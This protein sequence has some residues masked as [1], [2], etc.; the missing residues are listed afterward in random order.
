MQGS[1]RPSTALLIGSGLLTAA[2][3]AAT[4]TLIS[5]PLL[6]RIIRAAVLAVTLYTPVFKPVPLVKNA[7]VAGVTSGMSAGHGPQLQSP[8]TGGMRA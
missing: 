4:P 8:P 2:F 1:V 7:V 6:R 5:S 3:A